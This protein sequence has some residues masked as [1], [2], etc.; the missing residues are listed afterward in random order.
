MPNTF[1]PSYD[2]S[3]QSENFSALG[4][5]R[6]KKSINKGF[7]Y[8]AFKLND[9]EK[10]NLKGNTGLNLA[11]DYLLALIPPDK[12]LETKEKVNLYSGDIIVRTNKNDALYNQHYLHINAEKNEALN[13]YKSLGFGHE[14]G[15]GLNVIV[16]AG[17]DI[18][19][20]DPAYLGFDKRKNINK[21]KH[22]NIIT[23]DNSLYGNMEPDPSKSEVKVLKFETSE[24][25]DL[26]E[27]EISYTKLLFQRVT[28]NRT[29]EVVRQNFLPSGKLM[30]QYHI[31]DR[32]INNTI[33]GVDHTFHLNGNGNSNDIPSTFIQHSNKKFEWNHP[34]EKDKNDVDNWKLYAYIDIPSSS[35]LNIENGNAHGTITQG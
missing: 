1:P 9:Y 7:T 10:M 31:T 21:G 33:W 19:I 18:L 22:H 5:A 29:I 12:R 13:G 28:I 27:L 35:V 16:V 34:C 26:I 25:Y 17:E 24:N 32:I 30:P 11:P 23:S 2:D 20:F 14:H 6:T 4:I 3:W 15:D 8:D